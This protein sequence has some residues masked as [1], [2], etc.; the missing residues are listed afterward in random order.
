MTPYLHYLLTENL[1]NRLHQDPSISS[2]DHWVEC[3]H[4]GAGKASF[5]LAPESVS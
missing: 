2:L 4:G 1:G 5:S 3:S